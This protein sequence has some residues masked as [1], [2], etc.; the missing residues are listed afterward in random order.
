MGSFPTRRPVS[1]YFK[2]TDADGNY[3]FEIR[4]VEVKT[5]D[6]LA[7]AG[8]ELDVSDRLKSHDLYIQFPPL[9]IREEGRYEFQIWA[10]ALFLGATFIDAIPRISP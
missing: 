6:I 2:V 3:D 10:N 7:K 4:Y 8:G 1:L 5:G 9:L